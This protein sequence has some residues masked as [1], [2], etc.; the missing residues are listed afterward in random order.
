VPAILCNTNVIKEEGEHAKALGMVGEKVKDPPVLLDVGFGVWFKCTKNIWKFHPIVDKEDGELFPTRSKVPCSNGKGKITQ[1]SAAKQMYA[2]WT[3]E[4]PYASV[5][6]RPPMKGF[7]TGSIIL[8]LV[9][10]AH[11]CLPYLSCI[12]LHIRTPRVPQGFRATPFVDD[13]GETDIHRC[14]NSWCL[15]EIGTGKVRNVMSDLKESL[16]TGSPGMDNTLRNPL[17][18]KVGKFLH[19]V[20]IVKKNWTCDVDDSLP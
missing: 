5:E 6:F 8:V 20:I 3:R 2:M 14:L 17:P 18:I 4:L 11:S 9:H 1:Q 19:K 16:C 10:A 7:I 15:K 12:E 13:D